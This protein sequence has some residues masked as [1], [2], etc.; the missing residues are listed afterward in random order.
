MENLGE[1]FIKGRIVNLDTTDIS[2]L[3][4]YLKEIRENKFDY[5]KKLDVF[6]EKIY[7]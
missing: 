4:S 5:R 3:E 6:L 2:E 1:T 7:S